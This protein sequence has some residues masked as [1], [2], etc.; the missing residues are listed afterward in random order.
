MRND[1]ET[2]RRRFTLTVH[3]AS[4]FFITLVSLTIDYHG[5]LVVYGQSLVYVKIVKA[6]SGSCNGRKISGLKL[7]ENT[8]DLPYFALSGKFLHLANN[9]IFEQILAKCWG[10]LISKPVTIAL[11]LTSACVVAFLKTVVETQCKYIVQ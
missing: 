9:A 1:N 4:A 11:T 6:L 5:R 2:L 3:C 7:M 10:G 8:L